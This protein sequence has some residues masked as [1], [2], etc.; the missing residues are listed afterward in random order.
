MNFDE[1]DLSTYGLIVKGTSPIPYMPPVGIEHVQ[2]GDKGYDFQAFLEPKIISLDVVISSATL[3][4][5][6]DSLSKIL[7]PILGVKKLILDK[8]DDRYY[9]AKVSGGFEYQFIGDK[10]A[11]GSIQFICPDPMA[12]DNDETSSDHSITTDP[13]TVTEA[14]GGT[15][16]IEPVYTLTAG[17]ALND[18]TIKVENTDTEEEFQWEGS[19]A[20]TEKL[21][22]DVANW[23][24]EKEGTASMA[25]VS[26]QFPRLKPGFTNHIKVTGFSTTGTLNIKYRNRYL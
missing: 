15:G 11:V 13:K 26:G 21:G 19:L 5:D 14:T 2:V 22:I 18:V 3:E 16:Y 17:E 8:P 12:Y 20:N 9:N 7:N 25:T 4:S 1:T 10:I 24:V 6:L 23:M